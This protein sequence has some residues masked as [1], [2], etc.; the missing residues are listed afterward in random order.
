MLWLVVVLLVAVVVAVARGGRLTNLADIRLQLWWL[1]PIAFALQIGAGFL[2]DRSW[3]DEVGVGMIL[4]SYV[5]LVAV[6]IANRERKGMWLAGIGVLLNFTVIVLN[7]GMPVLSEA[8]VVASG[9]SPTPQ[10]A[11]SAKHVPLDQATHLSFLADVI[12]VRLF[13]TGTVLSLGDVFLAVGL[14]RFL[15]SELRRPVRWFKPGVKLRG[16]SASRR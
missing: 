1:L 2:P 14:G 10:I 5:P 12:P 3:A 8:A 7:A 6:V 9:F 11:D 15:E 4:L 13:G 16:G